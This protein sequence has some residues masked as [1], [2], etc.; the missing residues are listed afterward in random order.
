M[1]LEWLGGSVLRVAMQGSHLGAHA[2]PHPKIHTVSRSLTPKSTHVM[3]LC[4]NKKL[5]ERTPKTPTFLATV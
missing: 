1:R 2:R 4:V 3:F 5:I